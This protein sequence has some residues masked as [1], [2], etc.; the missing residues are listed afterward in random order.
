M[1]SALAYIFARICPLPYELPK[2]QEGHSR[3]HEATERRHPAVDG[4]HQPVQQEAEP[5]PTAADASQQEPKIG[6]AHV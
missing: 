2:S 6:R 3:G 4:G 1:S 5:Q